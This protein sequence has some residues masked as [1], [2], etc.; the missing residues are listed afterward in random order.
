M[1]SIL[2]AE[3]LV[4][5]IGLYTILQGVSVDVAEG[6]IVTI[7]GRNGAGKTTFLKTIM[8]M[9]D[10]RSG[11]LELGG[12]S[13]VGKPTYEIAKMGIGYVPEDYGVF[14]LLTVQE[15]LR[16][17][18]W[19]TDQASW[20]RVDYVLNLFPDLKA[21]YKRPARSLSGGQ[22]QMLSVGRSMVND[23]KI[24]LIDE[25]SKGLA[26]VIIEKMG[27]AFMEIAKTRTIL[28]VE[29]NFALACAVAK[30]YYIVNEGRTVQTGLVKDL[31]L[32]TETQKQYLGI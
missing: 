26:P 11:K 2:K 8:G 29:Q 19:K 10:V 25:P 12:Q 24:I 6:D 1:P 31:M 23:N 4:S 30:R 13:I 5:Y 21:A 32:D 17:P 3:D 20:D 9:V 7:L 15:N 22:R 18:M 14:D 27:L 16:L 28:L